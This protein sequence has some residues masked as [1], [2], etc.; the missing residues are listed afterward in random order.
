[1]FRGRLRLPLLF[2]IYRERIKMGKT[3][4]NINEEINYTGTDAYLRDQLSDRSLYIPV[5]E[6]NRL[7]RN[8]AIRALREYETLHAKPNT[9]KVRVTFTRSG[10]ANAGNYI[11]VGL[12][13]KNWQIPYDVEVVLPEYVLTEVIDRSVIIKNVYEENEHGVGSKKKEVKVTV[14]PYFKHGYV[15]NDEEV[16]DAVEIKPTE[17]VA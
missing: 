1:M 14:Y 2:Y 5:D 3:V 8:Q 12:N 11:Y 6:N 17:A 10:N 7:L 15:E 9:R 13:N 4:K 16:L